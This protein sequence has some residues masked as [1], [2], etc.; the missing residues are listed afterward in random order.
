M[1][2]HFVAELS[3]QISLFLVRAACAAISR[4]HWLYGSQHLM[5]EWTS[6]GSVHRDN[7]FLLRFVFAIVRPHSR[8]F[9]A[10]NS[11]MDIDNRP[12]ITHG[13]S[14]I[15]RHQGPSPS[16]GNFC[17]R[18]SPSGCMTSIEGVFITIVFSIFDLL[19]TR[20]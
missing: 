11:R 10:E 1:N 14:Y 16:N 7:S 3:F 18:R 19:W 6:S 13:F 20:I 8:S 17:S 4:R 15:S 12:V 5:G 9:G 2:Q